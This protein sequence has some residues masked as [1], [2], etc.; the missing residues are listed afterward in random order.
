MR[1]FRRLAPLSCV[2]SALA[3]SGCGYVHIGKLPPPSAENAAL[4]AEN[5]ALRQQVTTLSSEL[6]A[7]RSAAAEAAVASLTTPAASDIAAPAAELTPQQFAEIESKLSTALRSYSLLQTEND[8]LKTTADQ[9]AADKLSLENQLAASTGHASALNDQL[10]TANATARLVDS[11]RTQLR[12]TQDQ[13]NAVISEYSALRTRTAAGAPSPTSVLAVPTRPGTALFVATPPVDLK[14]PAAPEP[15][16][17]TVVS[18]DTLSGI[19]RQYLGNGNRWPE[20]LAANRAKLPDD[21]SLTI[22]MKLV[23][24]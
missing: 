15:R 21:R 9:L 20:I 6:S 4:A 18:G 12:Q 22:G 5:A 1:I 16:T 8:Q 23:I 7:A 19:A 13:L 24:P 3:L 11:L 14:T 17:H 2:L 10:T